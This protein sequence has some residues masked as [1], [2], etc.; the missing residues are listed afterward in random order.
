M[1]KERRN[2]I[3]ELDFGERG[4]ERDCLVCCHMKDYLILMIQ[5]T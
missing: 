5:Y 1:V 3:F 4:R 2:L